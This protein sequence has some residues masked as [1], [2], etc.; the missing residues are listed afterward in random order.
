M[1]PTMTPTIHIKPRVY[2]DPFNKKTLYLPIIV[3]K[4]QNVTLE[5]LI[6]YAID[7]GHIAGLKGEAV[8]SIVYG[9]CEAMR[10]KLIEGKCVEF[11]KYFRARPYIN[12]KCN[13]QGAL[14]G[15][16][17]INIRLTSGTALRVSMS[18]VHVV[19]DVNDNI[20]RVDFIMSHDD[21]AAQNRAVQG[22]DIM[23]YGENLCGKKEEKVKTIVQIWAAEGKDCVAGDAPVVEIDEFAV[24]G[25]ALMRFAW[26][27]I[28]V[29]KRFAL[30]VVHKRT[31][32]VADISDP[33]FFETVVPS[34]T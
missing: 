17:K 6:Y 23:V 31:N 14:A 7:T 9:L 27:N 5:A 4:D 2:N 18:D 19:S 10:E 1:T 15:N 30:K 25:P 3:D 12:G 13:A 28:E 11:G 29:G 26:P 24:N 20:A 22:S 34:P 21:R 32:G 33:C 16:N 8:L